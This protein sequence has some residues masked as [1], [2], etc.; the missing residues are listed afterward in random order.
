MVFLLLMISCI[1]VNRQWEEVESDYDHVLNVFGILNLDPGY[2]SFIGLYRTTNL[3]EVS[4]KFSRVD[5]L[6]YCDCESDGGKEDDNC[7]CEDENGY[8]VVDSIYEPAA[9]IKDAS[10]HITDDLGQSFEFN[11]MDNLTRIDSLN[12]D[13]TL[14]IDG[15]VIELDTTIF[16]TNNIRLNFYVDTTGYFKPEPGREYGLSITAPGYNSISGNLK[17]PLRTKINSVYQRGNLIDTVL[18]NEPFE[19]SYDYQEIGRALVSGQVLLGD[20]WTDSTSSG[21]C[22]GEFD[23]FMVDLDD[24]ELYKQTID[25]WICLEQS[26]QGNVKDYVL[27]LTS[28][29]NNYYD[30]F[31]VGESGEYSNALLNYPTTKGRSVGLEGGFGLFGSIASDWKTVK[32]I[33]R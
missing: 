12:I 14:N 13:T 9:I 15:Y 8:W 31:V 20:W 24:G 28:M 19:I 22:G 17:T 10:I 33:R 30:Y 18:V 21:W 11:F 23:P 5:T 7:W 32:I 3:N 29:D 1:G 6:Y 2:S 25:P 4:Q 26:E 27:R 16:D